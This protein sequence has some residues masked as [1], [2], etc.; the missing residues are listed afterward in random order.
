MDNVQAQYDALSRLAA[1]KAARDAAAPGSPQYTQLNAQYQA[2]LQSAGLTE[3]QAAAQITSMP[4]MKNEL[5]KN[6]AEYNAAAADSTLADA[7][8]K[9]DGAAAEIGDGETELDEKQRE[10]DHK[11]AEADA[12][13]GDAA[14][15]IENA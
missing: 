1:L 4:A 9:L 11:K 13:L 5:D 14:Q 12:E 7:K 10:Y 8:A 15:K 2:A 6:W 3:Q